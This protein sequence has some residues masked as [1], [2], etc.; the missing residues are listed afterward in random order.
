MPTAHSVIATS[1]P[2][3]LVRDTAATIEV[4]E[5]DLTLQGLRIIAQRMK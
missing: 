5:P 3:P 4:V 2:A 1:G